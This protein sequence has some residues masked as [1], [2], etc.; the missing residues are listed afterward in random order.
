MTGI[1]ILHSHLYGFDEVYESLT[2]YRYSAQLHLQHL[3]RRG[4]LVTTGF[5]T[6]NTKSGV[7]GLACLACCLGQSCGGNATP[8]ANNGDQQVLASTPDAPT[9]LTDLLSAVVGDP[10]SQANTPIL[11]STSV[12]SGPAP[13]PVI[14]SA[15]TVDG[16]GSQAS[17]T[18]DFGDGSTAGGSTVVHTFAAVG[19][20][21]VSVCFIPPSLVPDEPVCAHTTI[22]ATGT[23]TTGGGNQP[24]ALSQ[25]PAPQATPQ[26]I[27]IAKNETPL[28]ELSGTD[29]SGLSIGFLITQLP[30]H[31]TLSDAG[32]G[33]LISSV[34][35][36]YPVYGNWNVVLYSPAQDFQGS[37]AFGF[38][39][40]NGVAT[41]TDAAITLTVAASTAPSYQT[42][43][44]PITPA[45][46]LNAPAAVPQ[47][48]AVTRDNYMTFVKKYYDN[49][50]P[51]GL[52]IA[53]TSSGRLQEIWAR[54]E[55]FFYH[56]TGDNSYATT[57]MRF[58]RGSN[59]YFTTGPGA[60][61]GEAYWETLIA[62]G[63]AWLWI[64][65]STALTD[66]DRQTAHNLLITIDHLLPRPLEFGAMN[67]SMGNAAGR[68]IIALLYPGEPD[69]AERSS[70]CD[71]VW[72]D[73]WNFRDTFENAI[74][75]NS[76]WLSYV[77][78]WIT[79]SGQEAVYQDP[80]FIKLAERYMAQATPLG[81]MPNYGSTVGLSE[82]PGK[83][84]WLFE[85]WA[86]V[87]RDGRYK[88]AAHRIFEWAI[89]RNKDMDEWGNLPIAMADDLMDAW[90][91]TDDTVVEQKPTS[92]SVATTRKGIQW[93]N[94]SHPMPTGYYAQS[95]NQ[96]IPDKLVLR[97]G[98][99]PED[100]YALVELAPYMG[101]GHLDTGSINYITSHGSVLTCTPPY[102]VQEPRYHNCFQVMPPGPFDNSRFADLQ[103]TA[104]TLPVMADGKLA[105]YAQVHIERYYELPVTLDRR[106]F[107]VKN[108]L[109]W[110]QDTVTSTADVTAKVGP[111]WQTVAVY[112]TKGANW[113]NTCMT[114]VPLSFIWDLK[115]L[116]QWTNLPWDLLV[117]YLPQE[118]VNMK[119]EDVTQDTTK[120]VVAQNLQNNLKY[121]L[122]NQ[123]DTTLKAGVPLRFSSTLTPHVPMPDCSSLAK[124]FQTIL[125]TPQ[126]NVIQINLT[127][128]RAMYL[129]INDNGDAVQA[130]PVTTDAKRFL[131]DV[132]S[133]KGT[134]FWVLEA[135]NLSV[136]NQQLFTSAQRDSRESLL[137]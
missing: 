126:S 20:Y 84:I 52:S 106:I 136:S 39:V 83:W 8:S 33:S 5:H 34:E 30:A 114:T 97:S 55:A 63:Q 42:S 4:I 73:G 117:V 127:K 7:V 62:A 44:S 105:T 109:I 74:S 69:A 125:D 66:N 80:G 22:T 113:A 100:L 85:N 87:Y 25:L 47:P 61:N 82:E 76:L 120:A 130:G 71:Q 131:V 1:R 36:P 92:S 122:W 43:L 101:H 67:R 26:S 95:T 89:R 28:I 119:L 123:S 12:L 51:Y 32:T 99:N 56:I 6:F 102:L 91:V 19:V 86:T 15:T 118:Q 41:S 49:Q 110:V 81:P 65:D 128:T 53:G 88:W 107:F 98:W 10:N 58:L 14:L 77:N 135:T 75:Y 35:L 78:I 37:D 79:V 72:N 38:A 18:W 24:P 2:P 11:I 137:P 17:F 45:R 59:A 94:A 46:W 103:S 133:D 116:M 124:A 3:G 13:L 112:P 50:R 54:R 21:T 48:G 40:N 115:Y 96:D 134:Q 29:S 31:G 111:A 16:S 27:A 9:G 60:T 68:K 23:S 104:T 57:A 129:G 64:K 121:R 108:M 93:M 70:Y 90:L 132:D